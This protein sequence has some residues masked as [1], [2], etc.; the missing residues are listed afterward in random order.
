MVTGW[1]PACPKCGSKLH[2]DPELS[3]LLGRSA[4]TFDELLRKHAFAK[5]VDAI[6]TARAP[7]RDPILFLYL[8]P[9]S[10][11]SE[12]WWHVLLL[13]GPAMTTKLRV[14]AWIIRWHEPVTGK[15]AQPEGT[16]QA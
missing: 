10:G 1:P 2:P 3:T 7:D 13:D 6:G 15:L 9:V 8:Q 14:G 4:D 12:P 16:V 5:H 11:M